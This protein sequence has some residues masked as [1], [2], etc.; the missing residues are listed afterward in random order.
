MAKLLI[1]LAA[2]L[3][4]LV[5]VDA[6][7]RTTII[8]DETDP[9]QGGRVGEQPQCQQEVLEHEMLRPCHSYMWDEVQ[10]GGGRGG[11]HEELFETCCDLIRDMTPECT[12]MGLQAV[13]SMMEQEVEQLEGQQKQQS[14][15]WI[16]Q[17]VGIAKDL[18][19]RCRADPRQCEIRSPQQQQPAWN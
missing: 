13:I 9:N 3:L 18:P 8:I 6:S 4:F 12:C 16:Q 15:R 10:S 14:K 17:A 2:A 7:V 11:E 5:V 19:Q 1:T